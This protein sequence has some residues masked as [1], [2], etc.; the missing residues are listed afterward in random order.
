VIYAL[1]L[2]SLCAVVIVAKLIYGLAV[3]TYQEHASC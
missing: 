3:A 1:F 2:L